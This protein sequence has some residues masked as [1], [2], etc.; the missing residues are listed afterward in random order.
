MNVTVMIRNDENDDWEIT[1]IMRM[2]AMMMKMM[3]E[4]LMVE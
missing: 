3:R 2:M 1:V 4:M